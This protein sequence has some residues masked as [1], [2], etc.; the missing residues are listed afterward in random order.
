[1]EQIGSSERVHA[2]EALSY[3][4]PIL[5]KYDFKWVITGGFAAYAYGVNRPITDIDIDVDG[6]KEDARFKALVEEVRP[7]MT[8]ELIHF[9]DQ[10]YDNYNFEITVSG[11]VI[12]ICPMKEMNV[13][14]R[15][16]GKYFGFYTE[17][18]PECETV[19]FEG[20]KIPLLSKTLII[21]NKEIVPFQ[22]ES[23]HADVAALRAML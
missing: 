13:Y 2:R 17:G 18:F 1:M 4:I 22:R 14:D 19:E 20:M 11:I 3:I 7:M 23:D 21:K 9:V 15:D 8:Q 12:D 6:S 16:A 10:N 5:K